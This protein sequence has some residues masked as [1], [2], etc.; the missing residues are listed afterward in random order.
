MAGAP[1]KNAAGERQ[2]PHYIKGAEAS[3]SGRTSEAKADRKPKLKKV[4]RSQIRN[5]V[6]WWLKS[7]R[8]LAS[9]KGHGV[10]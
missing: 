6:S 2:Q 7:S 1:R 9:L 5:C 8:E 3:K 4:S 10:Q